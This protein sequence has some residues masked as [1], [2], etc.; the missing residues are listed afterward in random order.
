MGALITVSDLEVRDG[1][2][3]V[4]DLRLAKALGFSDI[5]MIRTLIKRHIEALQ[6]FGTVSVIQRKPGAKGGRPSTVFYLN[7][8]Q[9]I[10]ITAKS[11]TPKAAEITVE[12]V[13]VFRAYLDEQRKP[14][15]VRPHRR[16]LPNP[17][18]GSVPLHF[19]PGSDFL[20]DLYTTVMSANLRVEEGQEP[21]FGKAL[22]SVFADLVTKASGGKPSG[23]YFG[24]YNWDRIKGVENVNLSAARKVVPAH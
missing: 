17:K 6:Q 15:K 8:E 4:E 10:F 11:D 18:T 3:R 14:V 21:N 13:R 5:H 9:A 22:E 2:A 24:D 16:T 19:Q 12:M 7:E 23:K 1:V 20:R